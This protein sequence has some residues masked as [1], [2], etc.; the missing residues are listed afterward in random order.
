MSMKK[1]YIA[2]SALALLALTVVPSQ[3]LTG[4][5]D[6]VEAN[7][8][9]VPVVCA[10]DETLDTLVAIHEVAGLGTTANPLNAPWR[11]HWQLWDRRSGEIIN[12]YISYTPNDVTTL[13]VGAQIIWNQLS[14]ADLAGIAADLDNDGVND[15]Y[16]CY[17]TFQDTRQVAGF[18][19]TTI[20]H[21]VGKYYLANVTQ[22]R[23]AGNSAAGRE[24]IDTAYNGITDTGYHPYQRVPTWVGGAPIYAFNNVNFTSNWEAFSPLAYAVSEWREQGVSVQSQILI[25]GGLYRGVGVGLN[26]VPRWW[27]YTENGENNIFVWKSVNQ[28][29]TNPAD[30]ATIGGWTSITISVYDNEEDYVSR[31]IDLPDELNILDVKEII[32]QTWIPVG[33]LPTDQLGGWFDIPMPGAR[34]AHAVDLLAW[35]WQRAYNANATLNWS[36]LFEVNRVVGT[37]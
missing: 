24:Y 23:A 28:T 4:I 35:N 15:H 22:G 9:T 5:D 31:N 17:I 10:I 20:N 18:P 3:A 16:V 6:L 26:F 12:D 13:A 19:A 14:P 33:L 29:A 25:N 2:L 37:Y 8:F 27:L 36:A 11:L 7:Q 34:F 32:P 1:F 30:P 21:L